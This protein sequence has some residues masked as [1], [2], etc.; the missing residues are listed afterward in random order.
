MEYTDTV[1]ASFAV[2]SIEGD[3]LTGALWLE[4]ADSG[5]VRVGEAVVLRSGGTGK[6]ISIRRSPGQALSAQ[7][8]IGFS[9]TSLFPSLRQLPVPMRIAVDVNAGKVRLATHFFR[10]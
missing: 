4:P 5:L 1:H 10:R 6:V 8:V 7:V 9:D 2:T 3:A